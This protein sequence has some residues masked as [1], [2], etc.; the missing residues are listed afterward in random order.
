MAFKASH[1]MVRIK[2]RICFTRA[3]HHPPDK[4]PLSKE[5]GELGDRESSYLS[6][7]MQP[8]AYPPT[9][10]KTCSPMCLPINK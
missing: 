7:G 3:E 4:P 5:V 8:H 2:R 9:K 1:G 10:V 6:D